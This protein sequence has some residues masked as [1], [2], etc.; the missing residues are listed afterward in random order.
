MICSITDRN[1]K[2]K[3]FMFLGDLFSNTMVEDRF[4]VGFVGAGFITREFHAR[5]F[6]RIRDAD[7][8]GVMNPTVSKAEAVADSCREAGER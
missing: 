4:G 7:V 8:A 2:K 5:T 3:M 6:E 1:S